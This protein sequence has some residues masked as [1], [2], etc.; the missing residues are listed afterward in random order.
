M[1]NEEPSGQQ[2]VDIEAALRWADRHEARERQKLRDM[3]LPPEGDMP[4]TGAFFVRGL[5]AM[6]RTAAPTAPSTADTVAVPR[7]MLAPFVAEAENWADSVPDDYR[8]PCAEPG[9]M[10]A[11]PGSETAYTVGDLRRLAAHCATA[12]STAAGDR[13]SRV[14]GRTVDAGPWFDD[15]LAASEDQAKQ[16][17]TPPAQGV[18]EETETLENLIG[19][20]I[21]A[22][23]APP[24]QE[25]AAQQCEAWAKAHRST[26][27]ELFCRIFADDFRAMARSEK[28]EEK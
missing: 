25:Q 16:A 8:A 12:P 14:V 15:A 9:K 24:W 6:L 1:G 5:V 26:D 4:V 17:A 2:A 13:S 18:E 3:G 21:G 11:Y 28:G 27:M 22:R 23:T 10:H 7:S 19:A 20:A